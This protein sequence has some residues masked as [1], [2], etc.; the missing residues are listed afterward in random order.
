MTSSQ[1]GYE[2]HS[3]T[4]RPTS[5]TARFQYD[6]ATTPP[7]M[8]AV[9]ALAEVMDVEPTELKPLQEAV[10]TDALDALAVVEGPTNGDVRTT[11]QQE[12]YAITVHSHG[13]VAIDPVRDDRIESMRR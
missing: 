10:D 6:R 2:V 1:T 12:G 5:E 13:M 4:R 8:A 11:W 3:E 7:S 9:T